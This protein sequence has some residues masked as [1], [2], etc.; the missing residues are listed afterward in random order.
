MIYQKRPHS[1]YVA[2]E[3]SAK[4]LYK[5]YEELGK[6]FSQVYLSNGFMILRD[7]YADP[8]SDELNIVINIDGE[9]TPFYGTIFLLKVGKEK[10]L[11]MDNADLLFFMDLFPTIPIT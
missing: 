10:I 1:N 5:L 2:V 3:T 8:A 4:T 11:P 7:P 9:T 6:N